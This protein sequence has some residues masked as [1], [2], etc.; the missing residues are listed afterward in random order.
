M[1]NT[2]RISVDLPASI[3]RSWEAIADWQGQGKWM[4]QTK[5]WV[6]SEI[7]EGVGT[8]IAAFTGPFHK[9]YP[10]FAKLGLLDEMEVTKWRPPFQCEVIHTGAILKGLGN[11]ELS[12]KSPTLTRFD[13]SETIECSKIKFLLILPFLWVGVRISLA[14]LA[15][16]LR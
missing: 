8:A 1:S 16:S 4:L 11:F 6:T 10:K 5:V 3:T 13:W 7:N 15:T 14:R 12:E 9:I 2:I